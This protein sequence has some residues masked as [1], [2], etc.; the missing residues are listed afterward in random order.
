MLK[1][2]ANY[3]LIK[4]QIFGNFRKF[5]VWTKYLIFSF[6]QLKKRRTPATPFE[7]ITLRTFASD[8]FFLGALRTKKSL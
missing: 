7:V 6:K 5:F 2:S 4:R 8:V 3:F 1:V